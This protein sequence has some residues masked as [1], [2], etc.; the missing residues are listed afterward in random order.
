[1]LYIML[2]S[3]SAKPILK[4]RLQQNCFEILPKPQVFLAQWWLYTYIYPEKDG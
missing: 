4:L 1:M 3:F 2:F